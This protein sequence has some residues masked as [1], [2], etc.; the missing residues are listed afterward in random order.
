M[1]QLHTRCYSW[2]RSYQSIHVDT[3]KMYYVPGDAAK[4]N[5]GADSCVG[6]AR[7]ERRILLLAVW[8]VVIV[9]VVRKQ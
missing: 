3:R 9:V 4:Q 5:S 7:A 8:T 2:F 6:P 1:Y